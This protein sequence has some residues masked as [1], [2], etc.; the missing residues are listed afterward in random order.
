MMLSDNLSTRMT[1]ILLAG[2]AVM[3]LIGAALLV[4]PQGRGEGGVRFYQLPRPSEALAIIEAVE[5]S[6]PAAR[7]RW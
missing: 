2:L 1:T 5:A 4:W 3:L 7:A 6:P